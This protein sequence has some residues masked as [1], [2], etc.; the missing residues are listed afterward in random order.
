MV[1]L[2]KIIYDIK[3]ENNKS[4]SIDEL[5]D[6]IYVF[7]IIEEGIADKD[8][9]LMSCLV[10]DEGNG[11]CSA[12]ALTKEDTCKPKDGIKRMIYMKSLFECLNF[13]IIYFKRSLNGKTRKIVINKNNAKQMREFY[14]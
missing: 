4:V 12:H 5:V 7:R 3:V 11:S 9:L 1:T 10:R 13:D 2:N 6:G 14:E 8:N